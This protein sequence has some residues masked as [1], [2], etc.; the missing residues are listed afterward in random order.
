[1]APP[2]RI[3][4]KTPLATEKLLFRKAHIVEQFGQPFEID[5]E[6]LSLDAT[7]DLQRLLGKEI[8][9]EL[10]LQ[11]GGPRYFN[12]LVAHAS[13]SGHFGDHACYRLQG[14]PRLWF[15]K[16]TTDCRIYQNLTAIDIVKAIFRK[17]GFT[18]FQDSSLTR[19]YRKR[20][21]CVQYRESDF[22]FVQRLMEE[23]GISREVQSSKHV[24]PDYD[25]TKPRAALK[26]QHVVKRNSAR[27]DFEV[28]DC[29]GQ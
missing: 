21:Y 23:E 1:M 24:L 8:C 26:T 10:P 5:V 3:S 4:I 6:L 29:P 16:C 27:S 19:N 20:D 22:N 18:D 25:F 11:E 7:L 12:A 17:H 2:L 14:V 15:L 13:Q 28:F 9:I